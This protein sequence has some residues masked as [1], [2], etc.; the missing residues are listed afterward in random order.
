[1]ASRDELHRHHLVWLSPGA[2]PA[3][4]RDAQAHDDESLRVALA[5]WLDAKWPF[6]VRRQTSPAWPEVISLGMPLPPSAGKRRVALEVD[7]RSI[8]R[9]DVP[10]HLDEVIMLLPGERRP[11]LRRLCASAR[12]I[13]VELSVYG[14]C[15]LESL[16]GMP[17]LGPDSDI[18]LL[19]RPV[20]DAGLDRA[21]ALL[22]SWENQERWRADG[23]I[24]LGDGEGE[25]GVS[26][27]EW[28]AAERKT[29]GPRRVLV[30]TLRDVRLRPIDDLRAMLPK[31]ERLH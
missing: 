20:D 22:S 30:K 7:A 2:A 8:L 13:G 25:L 23:E 19:F 3:V 1:M 31:S 29:S 16:T 11:A 24:V 27:R 6:I 9:W 18:D 28:R 10:P 5:F 4:K 12:A 26:W 15:V 14:S 21:I 17:Y